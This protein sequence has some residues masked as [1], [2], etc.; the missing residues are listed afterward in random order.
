MLGNA[1]HMSGRRADMES[2]PTR[3]RSGGRRSEPDRN[4]NGNSR[5]GGKLKT[6]TATAAKARSSAGGK[7]P[8][9]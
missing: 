2:A 3:G 6:V 1:P 4:E 7:L 5:T 9:S 8:A